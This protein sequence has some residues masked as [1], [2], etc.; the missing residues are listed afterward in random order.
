MSLYGRLAG[1]E[2]YRSGDH[3]TLRCKR[4]DWRKPLAKVSL[5]GLVALAEGHYPEVVTLQ[6]PD[7]APGV[8]LCVTVPAEHEE[9]AR[10]AAAENGSEEQRFP[11]S[12]WAV[13]TDPKDEE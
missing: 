12:R 5:S 8:S 10:R 1:F 6:L 3:L 9:L 2:V 7:P 4:C 13:S 11:I